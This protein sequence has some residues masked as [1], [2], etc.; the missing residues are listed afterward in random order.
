ML[1]IGLEALDKIPVTYII[2]SEIALLTAEYAVKM[3]ESAT[4]EFC[5]IEAF[6]SDT[7]VVNYLR[8]RFMARDWK[9]YN[10]Q[11]KQIYSEVYE[12][13]K[14][15]SKANTISYYVNTQRENS[16][17]RNILAAGFMQISFGMEHA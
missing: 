3:N 8:I 10:K 6:R 12:K 2:R 11:V 13:T 16:L 17:N 7:S 5:W 4:A 14:I 9:Q 15:E 1:S